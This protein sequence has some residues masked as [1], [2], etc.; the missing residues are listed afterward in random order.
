M[1]AS[2]IVLKKEEYDAFYESCVAEV[3]FV[4]PP[5]SKRLRKE[6]YPWIYILNI[7]EDIVTL[8]YQALLKQSKL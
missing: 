5:T 4:L 2:K 3:K 1:E 6:N 7:E 8:S